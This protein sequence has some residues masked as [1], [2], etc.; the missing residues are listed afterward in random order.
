MKQKSIL[1]IGPYPK[2]ITGMALANLVLLKGL[3]NL[4]LKSDIIN[5]NSKTVEVN[6]GKITLSKFRFLKI[7]RFLY[8]VIFYDIIYITIGLTFFGVF[9]FIPFILIAKIFNK[10]IALHLHGNLL[11]REYNSLSNIKK[12]IFKKTIQKADIGI[13]LSPLLIENFTSFLKDPQIKV[14]YNFIEDDLKIPKEILKKTKN[15]EEL[16]LAF[17][18]NLIEEKGINNLIEAIFQLEQEGYKNINLKVAGHTI[19]ENPVLDQL[20]KLSN[21]EYIGVIDLEKKKEVLSW[22]TIFC[23]PTYCI[24]EAQPLSILEAMALGNLILTTNYGG[25]PDICTDKNAVFCNRNDIKDLKEKLKFIITNKTII[26]EKGL[27]NID[28]ATSNFSEEKYIN[29]IINE[30]N[31]IE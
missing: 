30:L 26:K 29:S 2:P 8:K 5:T 14:I 25:I 20:T 11:K 31:S 28:Y 16:N 13:V 3:K 15:Y 27:H 7:Y 9:K 23:L 4:K 6:L 10:K 21:A 17:I 1:I 24:T 22:S 18:S 19:K 12:L